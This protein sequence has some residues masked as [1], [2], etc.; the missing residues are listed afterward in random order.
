M[1]DA[2]MPLIEAAG[3]Q[4]NV[5]LPDESVTIDGDAVRLG[6]VFSNLLNNAAKYTDRGGRITV[7]CTCDGEE[8]VV[9][10]RDTGIGIPPDMLSRVFEMFAQVPNPLRRT[11]QG[12]GIG[13]YISKQIVTRHHGEIWAESAGLE[14]GTTFRIRLPLA[15]KVDDASQ[16]AASVK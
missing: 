14:Q 1:T 16:G 10:V 6:Q 11:E 7:L 3:H 2:S 9:S 13:L 15:P 5:S 8:A 12:L 4:I